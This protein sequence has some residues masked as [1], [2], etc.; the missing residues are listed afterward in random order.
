MDLHWLHVDAI[1]RDMREDLIDAST[2]FV[3]L[4]E[5]VLIWLSHLQQ[6]IN[7]LDQVGRDEAIDELENWIV[8]GDEISDFLSLANAR[9]PVGPVLHINLDPIREKEISYLNEK[10]GP[11]LEDQLPQNSLLKRAH[12][13]LEEL[14]QT[15][16]RKLESILDSWKAGKHEASDRMRHQKEKRQR[17]ET[18]LR[19]I[20][21]LLKDFLKARLSHSSV[22]SS[23]PTKNDISEPDQIQMQ[24]N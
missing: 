10:D 2:E 24:I 4:Y 11:G 6:F 1:V 16:D 8:T 23:R 14:K 15:G 3:K 20:Q 17:V 21:E 5:M 7:D 22:K 12:E 13:N 9:E 19:N 18:D